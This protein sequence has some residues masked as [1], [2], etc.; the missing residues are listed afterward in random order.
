[1]SSMVPPDFK[2]IGRNLSSG[3]RRNFNFAKNFA[4]SAAATATGPSAFFTRLQAVSVRGAANCV[5]SGRRFI[6]FLNCGLAQLVKRVAEMIEHVARQ[7]R[8]L[9]RARN[10]NRHLRRATAHPR[11]ESRGVVKRQLSSEQSRAHPRHDTTH[12]V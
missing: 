9:A 8:F 2:R 10:E 4:M 6:G 1:M 11:A 12:S 3:R 5:L 7:Q